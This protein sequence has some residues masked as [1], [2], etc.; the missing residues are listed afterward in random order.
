MKQAITKQ[1]LRSR[2]MARI[3]ST[4]TRPE[5]MLRKALWRA[6]LRFRLKPRLRGKPDLVFPG[7]RVA[8]FVDGCFWHGCPQH[9]HLPKSN[10]GYWRPKLAR[11]L[12]RDRQVDAELLE[13]GWMPLRI[14]EHEIALDLPACVARIGE[15]VQLRATNL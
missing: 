15:A 4:D 1:T 2:L 5:L 10:L 9:G 13:L 14:W 6:G 7:A 11:N 8:V 12:A 3:K